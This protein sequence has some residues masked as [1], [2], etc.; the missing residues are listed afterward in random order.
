MNEVILRMEK[1]A[2]GGDALS[3]LEDGRVCF[4]SHALT[5]ELVKVRLVQ[6]K[7]DY[8]KGVAIE[9]LEANKERVKPRC[10]LYGKCGGCSFQHAS[11][12]FQKES[13]RVA[14]EELFRRFSH[15]ELPLNWQIAFGEPFAYRNR[16][17]VS[18][19]QNSPSK[20]CW[21]FREEKSH[22]IIPIPAC[23]VLS[24]GLE[25]CLQSEMLP[26]VRELSLFD[27]GED[28]ISFYYP[29]MPAADF[30][31]FAQNRVRIEGKELSMDSSVFFQ[32][33]LGLLPELVK[34]VKK[35]AGEGD[36]LID[37]FSGVGFFAAFLE[38]SFEKVITVEREPGA[39][40]H[41]RKNLHSKAENITLPAEDW[42]LEN[43]ASG[44]DV[45]IVDP[46]RTG[47]PPQ[48]LEAICKARPKKILYV[49]CDPA[50]LA[51]DLA[52]IALSGYHIV[53][54]KGFGFYPQTSHFE[55]FLELASI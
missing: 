12:E 46:P 49:S 18:R 5:G 38:E 44:A 55:M 42:L 34:V 45:L 47:L 24:R 4:V 8:A 10:P 39:L 13:A 43:D 48:A 52:R 19:V 35:A 25:K 29:G 23:P 37:L 30:E 15:V 41:A 2:Q 51:R 33:N 3:H 1:M 32:S 54:A 40:R 21:G 22:K 16:V 14:V 20:V 26:K 50:T 11:L 6:N 17:R 31:K 7:K 27:N 36:R 9:I 53:Q 28:R